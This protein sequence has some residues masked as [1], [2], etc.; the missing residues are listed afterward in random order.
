MSNGP[1]AFR[2]ALPLTSCRDYVR[3]E[4]MCRL[5]IWAVVPRAPRL[6][7]A[8]LLCSE[9][10]LVHRITLRFLIICHV[11]G[12]SQRFRADGD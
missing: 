11:V 4:V 12:F 7:M 9:L 3:C 5:V 8:A 6:A 2:H 10:G 1:H